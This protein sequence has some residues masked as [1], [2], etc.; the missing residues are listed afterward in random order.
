MNRETKIRLV[1][2]LAA[3]AI[4]ASVLIGLYASRPLQFYQVVVASSQA[5]VPA[6]GVPTAAPETAA[7]ASEEEMIEE[8]PSGPQEVLVEKSV[9]INTAT[10]EELDRLPG[11]GPAIAQRIIDYRERNSGFY[12]IEELMDVSG[13]GEKT[14]AKLE[15]Y[16]TVE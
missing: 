13:I 11:V 1:L 9:N 10:L 8:E 2:F 16:I 14:F 6:A 7:S 5:P 12:D 4:T 15:P 3:A